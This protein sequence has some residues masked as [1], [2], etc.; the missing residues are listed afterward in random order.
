MLNKINLT[1]MID[2]MTGLTN[3]EHQLLLSKSEEDI[4][5]IYINHYQQQDDEQIQISYF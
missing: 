2:I 3:E 4:E 1:T 5:K